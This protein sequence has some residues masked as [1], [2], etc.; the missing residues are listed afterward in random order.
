MNSKS[1][2]KILGE[3][4]L[5][6]CPDFLS[7]RS[8]IK[9]AADLDEIRLRGEFHLAGVGQGVARITD[10]QVRNDETFWLTRQNSNP[11]Q[12]RVWRRI[13]LLRTAFNRTLFLGLTDFEGHY[14]V[15]PEGGY[16]ERHKD[17][18][19]L[20]SARVVSFVLYLN[21]DWKPADGGRLRV[22]RK[23]NSGNESF[24]DV[25]PVGGTMVCFLSRE[26]EHEVLLS[27]RPR[28][29]LTGWF[30]V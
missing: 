30:K 27:H 25:D 13:D 19:R 18:F 22:Y 26:M 28:Y 17:S 14:A 9:V 10:P 1:I 21:R 3:T 11:T 5:C 15:Y 12:A 7:P 6:V 24:I 4:G 20:D 29:S 16:Y 2:A 8:L 23:E